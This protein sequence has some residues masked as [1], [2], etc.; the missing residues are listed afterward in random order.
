M[1][2]HSGAMRR[3]GVFGPI[4]VGHGL[5]GEQEGAHEQGRGQPQKRPKLCALI[6]SPLQ[7]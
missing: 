3:N 4:E 5:T 7:C 2:G 1:G 6:I